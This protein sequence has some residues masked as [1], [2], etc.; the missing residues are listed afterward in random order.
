MAIRQL[1][2]GSDSR[3]AQH[4]MARGKPEFLAQ[5][6][7]AVCSLVDRQLTDIFY[8]HIIETKLIYFLSS[9]MLNALYF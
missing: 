1:A 6:Q 5:L 3:S 9:L 2:V 7:R 4:Y 8:E